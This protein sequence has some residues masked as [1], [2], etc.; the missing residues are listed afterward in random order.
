MT[1]WRLSSS[2]AYLVQGTEDSSITATLPGGGTAVGADLAIV[3]GFLLS[4]TLNVEVTT[5]EGVTPFTFDVLRLPNLTFV[6]FTSDVPIVNI[7]F[8]G[9]Y[10][11][12]DNFRF[13]EAAAVPEPASLATAGAGVLMALGYA[14]RKRKSAAA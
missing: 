2:G 6:G 8:A 11:V 3:N 12:V 1:P 9:D 14:W 13:G 10:T 4:E 7:R 5:A